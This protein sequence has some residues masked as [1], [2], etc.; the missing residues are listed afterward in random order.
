C[1]TSL[2][3]SALRIMRYCH[4]I[5]HYSASA[6][7]QIILFCYPS[8]M[9]FA[10]NIGMLIKIFFQLFCFAAE[11]QQKKCPPA[12]RQRAGAFM[13]IPLLLSRDYSMPV[14]V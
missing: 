13:L 6:T 5:I 14:T 12:A 7:G 10:N 11:P 4:N 1:R 9:I 3:V 2:A 8:V